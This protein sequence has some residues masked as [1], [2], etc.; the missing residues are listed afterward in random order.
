VSLLL[1]SFLSS[2]TA[3]ELPETKPTLEMEN[4]DPIPP[5][6]AEPLNPVIIKK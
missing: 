1:L 6:E 5:L 2:C 3:E 4:V